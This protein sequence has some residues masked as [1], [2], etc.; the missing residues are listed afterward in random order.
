MQKA[1]KKDPNGITLG[2]ATVIIIGMVIALVLALAKIYLSN[3]IYKESKEVNLIQR[4]VDALKAERD[5]LEQKVER[6]NFKNRVEDTIFAI[7]SED[8]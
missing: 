5:I 3:Q 1:R 6:L 8:A 4:R 7:T 2:M